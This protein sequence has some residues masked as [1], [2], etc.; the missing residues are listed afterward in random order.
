[1]NNEPFDLIHKKSQTLI[2]H[3]PQG[4]ADN[5]KLKLNFYAGGLLRSNFP[6]IGPNHS[7]DDLRERYRV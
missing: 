6:A 5:S 3:P 1:M 7:D 2:I 4:V